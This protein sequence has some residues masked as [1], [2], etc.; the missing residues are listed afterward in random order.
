M[1]KK[2]LS[3][4]TAVL[5]LLT[6]FFTI[7]R[8]GFLFYHWNFFTEFQVSEILLSLL[9]GIRFDLVVIVQTMGLICFVLFLL[10]N[11][12]SQRWINH[13]FFLLTL[14]VLVFYISIFVADLGY[15]PIIKR[16]LSFEVPL[17]FSD[18]PGAF[19]QAVSGYLSLIILYFAFIGLLSFGW[20]KFWHRLRSIPDQKA[21]IFKHLLIIPVIF[22]FLVIIGRGGL[23]SKPTD[24]N[25]AYRN[26]HVQLGNLTL[27]A[28]YTVGVSTVRD[29]VKK[30]ELLET[31]RAETAVQNLVKIPGDTFLDPEYPLLR[32]SISRSPYTRPLSNVVI[33]IMEAV[34]ALWT[35]SFNPSIKSDTPHIDRIAAQG[36]RFTRFFGTGR[37]TTQG[38]GALISSIPALPSITLINSPFV[39]NSLLSIPRAL[40]KLNYDMLFLSGYFEGSASIDSFMKSMGIQKGLNQNDFP[41]FEKISHTWGVWDE[42]VFDR[43]HSEIEQL[44]EPFLAIIEPCTTHSPF[45]VPDKKWEFHDKNTAKSEWKNVLRYSDASIGE[46][47]KKAPTL[48]SYNNTLFIITSDHVSETNPNQ[49]ADSARLPLIFF[50]PGG[51]IPPGENRSISSQTDLLPT[52]LDYLGL[53]PVHGSAGQSLFSRDPGSGFAMHYNGSFILWFQDDLVS[54]YTNM[55]PD[56]RYDLNTDWKNRKN[57]IDKQ[58]RPDIDTAFL[59]YMQTI[60]NGILKNRIYRRTD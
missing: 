16:H 49:Y 58:P 21:G 52:I 40:K 8:I 38:F 57:L 14:L 37:Y 12:S 45:D 55:V 2:N 42:F 19:R 59:A 60:Q 51:Q 53:N 28:P 36:L 26:Q 31:R 50:T 15:Y 3:T 44:Q 17:V 13:L 7:G 54:R 23:Q 27:N 33:I 43:F 34:P 39:Q 35:G 20:Y 47:F 1:I 6:L 32:K 18:L 5:I 10:G 24:E 9:A 4:L 48:A 22:I 11:W 29:R 41:D 56:S 30:L 46:F 25:F